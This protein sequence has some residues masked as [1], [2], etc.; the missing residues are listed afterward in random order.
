MSHIDGG[1][2]MKKLII[3]VLSMVVCLGLTAC[4][5]KSSN[6]NPKNK[7]ETEEEK[8]QEKSNESIKEIELGEKV[9]VKDVAEFTFKKIKWQE[10]VKP[11]NTEGGFTYFE[12]R[13][14]ETFLT[15]SGELKN[16]S[17]SEYDPQYITNVNLQI[18][19]KYD[20]HGDFNCEETEGT[21]FY[22]RPKPLQT[23]KI[24]MIIP[25]SNE[26]K[27]EFKNGKITLKM[28]SDS[29]KI[30]SP[31]DNTASETFILNFK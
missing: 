22:G 26:V 19:G 4:G 10:E 21:G 29:S 25:V 9:I 20:F 7:V 1:N 23:L 31:D 15:V 17:S 27:D 24:M 12:K 3:T 13:N 30:Q 5:E 14:G 8:V 2:F 11:S 18:N 16:L 28:V 6:D